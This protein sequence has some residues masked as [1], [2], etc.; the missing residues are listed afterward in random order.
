MVYVRYAPV[1][2]DIGRKAAHFLEESGSLPVESRAGHYLLE[3]VR[4][5]LFRT[6][7]NSKLKG[8]VDK[9]YRANAKVESDSTGDGIRFEKTGGAPSESKDHIQK[10]K[11]ASNGTRDL[12]RE[13]YGKL[14][15]G[16]RRNISEIIKDLT[17]ETG[18]TW[19][20][21]N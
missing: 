18:L 17:T 6:S 16:D 19:R 8:W 9:L 15:G 14:D 11:E 7:V 12:L 13:N 4:D 21:V 5:R 20:G 2:P 3:R 10:A 1:A